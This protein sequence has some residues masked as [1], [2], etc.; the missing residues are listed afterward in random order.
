MPSLPPIHTLTSTHWRHQAGRRPADQELD[1]RSGSWLKTIWTTGPTANSCISDTHRCRSKQPSDSKL[2]K[3]FFSWSTKS[4][5]HRG[6]KLLPSQTLATESTTTPHWHWISPE[7]N[8]N[9]WKKVLT[10]DN[11]YGGREREMRDNTLTRE[12]VLSFVSKRTKM[13]LPPTSTCHPS[14]TFKSQ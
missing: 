7:I 13:C 6:V 11:S 14:P 12:D 10:Y 8:L 9:Y 5:H 2:G 1:Q 3:L 4:P